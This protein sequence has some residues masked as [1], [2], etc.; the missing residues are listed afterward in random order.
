LGEKCKKANPEPS[1][2]LLNALANSD[3]VSIEP[4]LALTRVTFAPWQA[5]RFLGQSVLRA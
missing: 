3:R 5:K 4:A 1:I 2:E